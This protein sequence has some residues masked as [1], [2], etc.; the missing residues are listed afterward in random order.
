MFS[1]NHQPSSSSCGGG[2]G[3][4]VPLAEWI[5]HALDSVMKNYL[6]DLED[7]SIDG[8]HGDLAVSTDAYI[9]PALRIATSLAEQICSAEEAAATE[10]VEEA[11][12]QEE[13]PGGEPSNAN[14]LQIKLPTPDSN[15]SSKTVVHLPHEICSENEVHA[16]GE[17]VNVDIGVGDNTSCYLTVTRAKLLRTTTAA[18]ADDS[19]DTSQEKLRRINSLGLVFYELFSGGDRP[20][21]HDNESYAE[22]EDLIDPLPIGRVNNHHEMHLADALKI[23]DDLDESEGRQNPQ[24]K[25]VQNRNRHPAVST[26]ALKM[27]MIPEPLCDLVANMLDCINGEFSG[28]EAY[29]SMSDVLIDLRLMLD[30]PAI[31]LRDIDLDKFS[32]DELHFSETIFGRESELSTL[33]SA[34]QR[35]LSSGEKELVLITGAAGS[36]KSYLSHQFGDDVKAGG[37][38]F[39]SAK[40]DQLKQ[41]RPLSALASAFN[42]YCEALSRGADSDDGAK[43]FASELR[44]RLRND[45][46][47]YLTKMIP[48]LVKIGLGHESFF[49]LEEGNDC[50]NAQQRLQFLLC[51][52]VEA[53][54]KSSSVSIIVHLDD[55]HNAD[56]ASI[57]VINQLFFFM[58]T[59]K[60]FFL[61]SSREDEKLWKMLTNLDHFCVPHTQIKMDDLD[62]LA[63]NKTI[64][65]LLHLSPRLTRPLS[66]IAHH[67]TRGNALFFSR[68]MMAL[69]KEGLLHPSLSRRRWVWDEE[70]IRMKKVP[71]DVAMF[72]RNSIH[73]LPNDVQKSLCVMAC[74]GAS[75]DGALIESLERVLP[76]QLF[77]SLDVA[78]SEGLLDKIN[79]QYRF[80]HDCIQEAAYNMII[81][82]EKCLQHF[83]HGLSL[84]KLSLTEVSQG[85]DNDNLLFAAVLQLN[86]GGPAALQALEE[87]F[88][89]ATLNL[90]AGKKAMQMS[91][92]KAAYSFFDNGISFLRKKHW[93]E[94]YEL[95]LE[96]FSLAAK[97]ALTNGDFASM[98]LLIEQVL[99]N[100][101]TFEEKLLLLYYS[102]CSFAYS[103]EFVE[104]AQ[105]IESILSQLGEALPEPEQTSRSELLHIVEQTK[106]TLEKYSVGALK[107]LK[108]IEDPCKKITMLFLARLHFC[109]FFINPEKQPIVTTR[110]VYFTLSHGMCETS[111]LAFAFFG[112]ML[113]KLGNIEQGYQY[114]KL[115]KQL[116]EE[117]ASCESSGLALSTA[118]QL[119]CYVEPVQAVVPLFIE[120]CERSMSAGDA[121]NACVTMMCYCNEAYISGLVLPRL[122]EKCSEARRLMKQL[123]HSS[124]LSHL[125]ILERHL[126][127]LMGAPWGSDHGIEEEI[128]EANSHTIFYSLVYNLCNSYMFRMYCTTKIVVQQFLAH[129]RVDWTLMFL[130]SESTFIFGL[131]SFWISRESSEPRW[132]QCGLKAKEAMREWTKSSKWNFEHKFL[133]LDAENNFCDGNLEQATILYEKAIKSAEEHRFVNGEALACELAGYFYLDLGEKITA[134]KYFVKAHEA[135]ELWGALGKAAILNEE[136]EKEFNTSVR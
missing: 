72:F 44:S 115:A 130:Q 112:S 50:V 65:E 57:G 45:D 68:W 85:Q 94:H 102:I 78:V 113:G 28:S 3:V 14:N 32:T 98:K 106:V 23:I 109:L 49:G 24:K 30:Q 46:V 34:Y 5:H 2:G 103:G 6:P 59:Q 37:G 27:K 90:R 16:G 13:L 43:S 26:E 56:D 11:A 80:S 38:V 66:I 127:S 76:L 123:G 51:Q 17:D 99:K 64:S 128:E 101:R 77:T 132:K 104:A 12:Y 122:K 4:V 19:D 74:F 31:F 47:F 86:L 62:E 95:S 22:V 61:A 119:F 25:S 126:Q 116:I 55:L 15:W 117:N 33:H 92:F 42:D 69:S 63:I 96:L 136:I 124:A 81:P 1:S 133:L 114:T 129:N 89:V 118:A 84:A 53:M 87:S 120:A 71:D 97:C 21:L 83:Q 8:D 60:I 9:V 107:N 39:L 36:G 20:L 67:K 40:F 88:I 54:A 91:D 110:M 29:R 10:D 93:Q 135:Y 70:E 100:A 121:T 79:Y 35:S 58:S 82:E 48:S 75:L 111:P 73:K 134:K 131:A 108:R 7:S 41:A 18:D 125:V 105:N 52:F